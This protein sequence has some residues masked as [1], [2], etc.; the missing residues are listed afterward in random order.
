MGKDAR[1]PVP[2]AERQRG[3]Q[4]QVVNPRCSFHARVAVQPSMFQR[5]R[6]LNITPRREN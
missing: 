3:S 5:P 4:R 6:K 2:E 1:C